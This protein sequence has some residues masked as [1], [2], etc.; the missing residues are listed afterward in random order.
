MN[1]VPEENLGYFSTLFLP[2]GSKMLWDTTPS[3][4]FSGCD[5]P[6]R[7]LAS[8]ALAPIKK[9]SL[10]LQNKKWLLRNAIAVASS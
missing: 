1:G 5:R 4:R 2:I 10:V 6:F 3:S 7:S 8:D 9:I